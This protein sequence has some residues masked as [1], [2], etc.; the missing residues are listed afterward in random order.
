[1]KEKFIKNTLTLMFLVLMTSMIFSIYYTISNDKFDTIAFI[2]GVSAFVVAILTVMYVFT[3]TK[4]LSVMESQLSEMKNDRELQN[5]PLPWII[6]VTLLLE[7]PRTYFYPF[8]ELVVNTRYHAKVKLKNIG[9]SPAIG[10]NVSALLIFPKEDGYDKLDCPSHIIDLIEESPNSKDIEK[11]ESFNLTFAPDTEYKLLQAL[12][13]RNVKQYPV[14]IITVVYKNI[15]GGCFATVNKYIMHPQKGYDEGLISNW[16]TQI[17]SIPVAYSS[18]IK[19]LNSDLREQNK[20]EW[21]KVYDK[22]KESV[23]NKLEGDDILLGS[24]SVPG[25]FSVETI[26][27]TEY[28]EDINE[29][30][31]GSIHCG[32]V[33]RMNGDIA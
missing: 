11:C 23:S 17:V 14:L 22:L 6:E 33:N 28:D 15:L 30:K 32:I 29:S 19:L 25:A 4:Q 20:E 21:D 24:T 10:A 2:S 16:H 12:R 13:N 1:M 8:M 18:E 7:K 5:Q 3:T 31:H 27:M 26:S 9:S